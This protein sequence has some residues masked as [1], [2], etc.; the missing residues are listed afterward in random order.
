MKF[1]PPK[2][3]RKNKKAP[4]PKTNKIKNKKLSKISFPFV[5]LKNSFKVIRFF[6]LQTIKS[7]LIKCELEFTLSIRRKTYSLKSIHI[8]IF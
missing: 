3:R 1:T 6:R 5:G 8:S 4:P 7:Y 2:E